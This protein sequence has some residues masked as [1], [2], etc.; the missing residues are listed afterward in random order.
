MTAT[1]KL[2]TAV[3]IFLLIAVYTSQASA[4]AHAEVEIPISV[5]GYGIQFFQDAADTYSKQSSNTVINL[6]GDPRVSDK[7]RVRIIEGNYPSASDAW[8]VPWYNLIRC[9]KIL[10]L[11]PYLD[12]PNWVGDAHWRDSFL[13]GSLDRWREGEAIWAIPFAYS[14]YAIF[15]N[16]SMFREHGWTIPTTWSELFVLCE[17]IKKEGIAPFAFPGVYMSYADWM[18]KAAYYNLAGPEEY[19][20]FQN[21]LPGTRSSQAFMRAASVVQHVAQNYFQPGWEGMSHTSAQLQLFKGN[22][23]MMANGSWLVGEMEGKIPSNF[24]LGTFNFPVFA[25]G[26]GSPNAIQVGSSYYFLFAENPNIQETIDF[27]RFLTSPQQAAQFSVLRDTPTAIVGVPHT[28]FSPLMRDVAEIIQKSTTAYGSPPGTSEPFPGLVQAFNDARYKLLTSTWTP[29]EF[30]TALEAAAERSR[31]AAATPDK[32]AYRHVWKGSGLLLLVF[33]TIFYSLLSQW[34]KRQERST[35]GEV[36]TT[37]SP[38]NLLLFL[39]PALL[40]YLFFTIKPCIES[41]AW[42]FTQWDGI[43]NRNFIGLLHFKHL[44]FDSDVFWKALKNNLFIMFVPTAFVVPL[45]LFFSFLISRGIWGSNLF[46]V[47]FF[48]P[49]ILGGIAVTLLWINA[50]DPQGGLVN[51]ALSRLGFSSFKN[52]AWLSQ[53]YLY[54]SLIPMAIWGACG[55]NMILYLAGMESVPDELYEAS[56]I[57]GATTWQQFIHITVPMIWEILIISSVFM[58]IGGLK[59]FEVIWLLTSQQPT[60][61]THVIGTW[62]VTTMFQEFRVGQA[63]AI[64]VVLFVL[65]FFG[66][67]ATMRLMKRETVQI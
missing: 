39:G 35:V 66:T 27:F 45:A 10:D 48:F 3:Y 67:M 40:M 58:V 4:S 36:T 61:N 19:Q 31:Q 46:R 9:G 59:A 53:E 65:V 12:E 25:N 41:F 55:F 49:N 21:V 62:M 44:L 34:K 33:G 28:S 11:A 54:W 32:V 63:T 15:Y 13:P 18:L 37:L 42:A 1:R 5:G 29:E 50:Y 7:V 64:A 16:K 51:G 14:V 26:K 60:S 38:V 8:G 47:C 57:D 17:N 43:T 30:C 56:A 22:A 24:E 23:A 2:Q 20:R 6:Y 52:F